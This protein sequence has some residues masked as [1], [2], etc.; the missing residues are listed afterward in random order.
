MRPNLKILVLVS[1]VALGNSTSY[2]ADDVRRPRPVEWDDL[3]FGG[4]FKDLFEPV[5][6]RGTPTRNTWGGDNVLPRDVLNGI[7]DS[8]WSYWGG[9]AVSGK[10]GNYHLYVCSER[11][12]PATT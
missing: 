9:N 5:P 10:D 3:V 6:L 8:D 11:V 12:K 4:Q 1:C 7:E 2:F